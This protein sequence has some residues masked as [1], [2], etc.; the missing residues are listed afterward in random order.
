[1]TSTEAQQA[2][3][4]QLSQLKTGLRQLYV[5]WCVSGPTLESS[6]A[7]AAMAQEE[8]G[9]ARILSRLAADATAAAQ[10]QTLLPAEQISSWPELVGTA[11]PLEVM[12]AAL[13]AELKDAGDPGVS[14]NLAKIAVEES[15]HAQFFLGWFQELGANRNAAGASFAAVR[16]QSEARIAEWLAASAA[17]FAEAGIASA[18]AWRTSSAAPAETGDVV[19]VHCGSRSSTRTG[20]FGA[21]LMTEL[22]KCDDCGANFESVRWKSST[23]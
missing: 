16:E 22:R 10:V 15:H 6:S 12:L 19:C 14:R 8:S 18:D 20:A 7:L 4:A 9:H 21:S 3:S 2:I 13:I 5:Q 1:M 23:A 11:G 17:L